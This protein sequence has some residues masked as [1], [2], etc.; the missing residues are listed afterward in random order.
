MLGLQGLNP[1]LAWLP[2]FG[3][4]PWVILYTDDRHPRVSAAYYLWGAWL[5]WMIFYHPGVRFG[6]HVQCLLALLYV[7]FFLWAFPPL[8]RRLHG[9][10][11]LPRALTVPIAWVATEWLR[12]TFGPGH[13]EYAALGYSQA[14]QPAL[15]QVADLTGVYGVSFLVAAVNGLLGD[16]YFELRERGWRAASLG[17]TRRT[18]WTAAGVAAA[19]GLAAVYGWV[20]LASIRDDGGGPR[21]A[22]V[23]PS[24]RHTIRNSIGVH[25]AQ[26]LLTQREIGRGTADLIVWPENAVLDNLFRPGAYLDDLAWLV[27]EKDA[28]L[29]LGAAGEAREPGRTTNGAFLI[30]PGGA[31]AGRYDKQ[32]LFPFSEY[33][34]ADAWLRR[35][36]PGLW[37]S[38][39]VL[40]REAWGFIPVGTAGSAMTLFELP[41]ASGRLAFAAVT[42]SENFYPP[43][44]AEAARRGARFLAHLTSEGEAGRGAINEQ[45]IRVCI[46]RAVE[47]R[48]PY[49]RAGNTGISCIIDATGR[50]RSLLRGRDGRTV[51]SVGTL[52]A[53]VPLRAG[54]GAVYPRTGDAFAK[55]CLLAAAAAWVWPRSWRAGAGAPARRAVC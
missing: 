28:W 31:V 41:S 21:V 48:I 9:V 5:Y 47:S 1:S 11:G 23:Q 44:P 36:L 42:C 52:T 32:V 24:V 8:V 6:W 38:Y 12:T 29:L 14:T 54:P 19:F 26:V 20:R 40:I 25:L 18:A 35:W 4:V 51:G 7:T 50:V 15:I 46:L 53:R 33:V 3:L 39:R 45:L 27:G 49:L 16:L 10:S 55:L 2:Y 34:P 13:L 30:D 17:P 43:V 37:R 22:I